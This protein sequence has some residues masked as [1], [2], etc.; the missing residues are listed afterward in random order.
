MPGASAAPGS[1]CTPA[2]A[3]GGLPFG[4]Y[5]LDMS[6]RPTISVL[7]T[8]LAVLTGAARSTNASAATVRLHATIAAAPVWLGSQALSLIESEH[9]SS[10]RTVQPTSAAVSA[11]VEVGARYDQPRIAAS[12]SLIALQG[13]DTE[14]AEGCKSE[15]PSITADDLLAAAPGATRCIAAFLTRRGCGAGAKVCPEVI[16][17]PLVSATTLVYE[18]CATEFGAPTEE[19]F[20]AISTGPGAP[21]RR[22]AAIAYPEALAGEWLVGLAPGWQGYGVKGER[23]HGPP[24]LV[25]HNLATGAEPLRLALSLTS[26]PRLFGEGEYPAIA[27]VQ[28]DGR[29]VYVTGTADKRELWTAS[30]DQPTPRALGRAASGASVSELSRRGPSLIVRDGRIAEYDGHAGVVVKD[31]DGVSLGSVHLRR[32]DGFDFDGAQVLLANTPCS[33]S[34]LTTWA[35][36]EPAPPAPSGR[37]RLP[38]IANVRFD[39]SR[40]R[41]ALACPSGSEL[42]C[43]AASV[44]L[45]R[46]GPPSSF[47]ELLPGARRTVSISL[48]LFARRVLVRRRHRRVTLYVNS[49]FQQAPQRAVRVRVP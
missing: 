38:N 30:P 5:H 25:E 9:G 39:R 11:S 14:C 13:V 43:P 10:L 44:Q 4:D 41:V 15:N 47:V 21:I 45:G 17:A 37:C 16:Q 48:G 33:E 46:D 1:A 3:R 19:P 22:L 35:V 12:Q 28:E 26:V 31:L 49:I 29:V 42:G 27:S 36:G 40:I 7:L 20:S 24:V 8:G 34:F 18:S 6:A 2:P 32:L 23:P